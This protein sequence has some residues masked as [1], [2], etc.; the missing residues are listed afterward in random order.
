MPTWLLI[1]ASVATIINTSI[2][3]LRF[4]R[5]RP[6]QTPQVN[7][8][9]SRTQKILG[10][11]DH[12]LPDHAVSWILGGSVL[13]CFIALIIE[14]RSTQPLNRPALASIVLWLSLFILNLVFVFLFRMAELL[15][16]VME[17]MHTVLSA[18]LQR[19]KDD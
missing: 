9:K 6:K 7:Q 18:L 11:I 8:P 16:G 13:I 19:R 2:A 3:V 4:V 1:A 15:Q 14:L 10:W 5:E 17:Q 12:V